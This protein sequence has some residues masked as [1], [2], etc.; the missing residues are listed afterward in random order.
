MMPCL[1]A[2]PPSD[3]TSTDS[4]VFLLNLLGDVAMSRLLCLLCLQLKWGRH[5]GCLSWGNG[6]RCFCC[7]KGNSF[8]SSR[9]NSFSCDSASL[10]VEGTVL[11][12][13]LQEETVY[14][15]S[16]RKKLWFSFCFSREKHWLWFCLYIEGTTLVVLFGE[17]SL[18]L[19]WSFC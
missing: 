16:Q 1:P 19:Q 8:L 3:L 4:R 18:G 12:L 5:T 6:L 13:L 17:Y 11:V 2:A 14:V 9:G 10:E 7:F 15:D